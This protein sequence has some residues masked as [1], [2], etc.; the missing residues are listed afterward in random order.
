LRV[1]ILIVIGSA[2]M[3]EA[4]QLLTPDWLGRAIDALVKAAGGICEISIGY[5]A[6]LLLQDKIDRI[7]E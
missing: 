1:V 4:L 7:K 6:T 5:L 3:L 2:F